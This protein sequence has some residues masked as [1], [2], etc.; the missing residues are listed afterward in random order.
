[1]FRNREIRWFAVLFIFITATSAAAGFA[2]H[3][4]AGIL[5]FVSAAAFGVA[6][7]AL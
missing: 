3:P 6:F 1:M 2:I 5:T 7:F 4:A